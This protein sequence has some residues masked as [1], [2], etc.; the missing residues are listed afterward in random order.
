MRILSFLFLALFGLSVCVAAQ[1]NKSSTWDSSNAKAVMQQQ[2]VDVNT[3]SADTLTS[4]KGLGPQRA[5]AIVDYRS[6][7]GN[8]KSLTDLTEVNGIGPKLLAKI[9]PF[10]MVH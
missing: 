4:I 1:A 5:A 3:A 8:F 9:S 2:K 6:K 10:L 7:H